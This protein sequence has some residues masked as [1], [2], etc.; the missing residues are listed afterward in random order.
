MQIQPCSTLSQEQVFKCETGTYNESA[1]QHRC[2][3][4]SRSTGLS[5]WQGYDRKL[6]AEL[7]LAKA[8]ARSAE[9]EAKQYRQQLAAERVGTA[10]QAPSTIASASGIT[11]SC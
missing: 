6:Q 2:L 3:Y 10:L 5:S 4:C 8:A 11:D 7:A 1:E 9:G